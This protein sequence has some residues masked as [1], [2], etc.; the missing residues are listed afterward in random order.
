MENLPQSRRTF[1]TTLT[2]LLASCGL[3]VRYLTP[4][5]SDKRRVLVSAAAA[6][7]PQ[8]G[9]LLFRN[10]RLAL[11]RDDSGFYALSLVCTHL[12]CTVTVTE[13]D[14]SCPCHGSRFDRQGTVLA[15]PAD[16]AL[17]R[18]KVEVRGELLEVV[19]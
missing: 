19:G 9:A 13:D 14:L 12:G 11:F 10:E 7:V 5:T 4:R 2:L 15:G 16:R 8:N 1:I 3:L 17:V 18:M 6:D